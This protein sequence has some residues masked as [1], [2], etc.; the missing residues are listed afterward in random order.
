MPALQGSRAGVER[1]LREATRSESSSRRQES[2]RNLLVALEVAV[3]LVLLVGAG[4]TL[5]SFWALGDVDPGFATREL[6]TARLH[7]TA[8][9]FGDAPKQVQFARRAREELGAIP[10]V[11]SV[12][13]VAPLPLSG[14]QRNLR[15]EIPDRRAV[16]NEPLSTA[17]HSVAPGY[18]STMGIRLLA[19]R[20]FTESELG[21]DPPSEGGRSVLIVNEAF[22]RSY[23]PG[24]DPIGKRVRI[25]YDDYLCDVVGVVENVRGVR[26]E[27]EDREGIYTLYSATPVSDIAITLR[28]ARPAGELAREV[29]Q[30]I[31]RVDPDQPVFAFEEM[32]ELVEAS[33]A[34]RRF[35]MT[36]LVSFAAVAVL[37]AALG[38]YAVISYGVHLRRREI[39]IRIAL[40][41]RRADVFE[42][43][44]SRCGKLFLAG[45]AAGLG[46]AL[47]LS[48]YLASELYGIS[49]TDTATYAAVAAMLGV[50]ALAA[51]A[52][53]AHR[54]SRE[55][56]LH[57]LRQQ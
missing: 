51:A 28:S 4:L 53:P 7:L 36:I 29:R 54:A 56:P 39:A 45:A 44:L 3:A 19:G 22:A 27:E 23:F 11:A 31:A 17:W 49:A 12:G 10:G 9:S 46:A 6:L 18:F 20:D 15:I 5:R 13:L 52:I 37:L 14:S 38:I 55:D 35:L 32:P 57:A 21:L 2:S 1:A 42:L 30:A 8:S 26:L 43:V 34:G 50:V 16:S 25:G 48:R 41:A 24:E 33:M 47:V 40:G